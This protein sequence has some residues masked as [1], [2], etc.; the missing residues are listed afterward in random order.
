M[1]D[2]HNRLIDNR[3]RCVKAKAELGEAIHR[4]LK[5]IVDQ[6]DKVRELNHRMLAFCENLQRVRDFLQIVQQIH[7]TPAIYLS[8]VAEV[9]RRRAFSQAYLSVNISLFIGLFCFI[10]FNFKFSELQSWHV[11]C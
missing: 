6:E 8:A 1:L 3:R 9:V 4:R 5:W 11:I 10:I 7:R 2:N